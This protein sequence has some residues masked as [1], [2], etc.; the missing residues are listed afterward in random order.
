MLNLFVS[1]STTENVERVHSNLYC[2]KLL[3]FVGKSALNI[4]Q[5]YSNV[6]GCLAHVGRSKWLCTTSKAGCTI[7]KY[8]QT[9]QVVSFSCVAGRARTPE[10][11]LLYIDF[12]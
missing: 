9:R 8:F 5:T 4:F 12:C 11:I 3:L 6:S 10:S 7:L 2:R 1:Y